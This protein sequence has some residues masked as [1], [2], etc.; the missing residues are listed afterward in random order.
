MKSWD[1]IAKIALSVNDGTKSALDLVNE[2]L[3]RIED[4][5]RL[6]E[7]ELKKAA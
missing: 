2:S 1:N 5:K 7:P 3:S 4:A 6:S